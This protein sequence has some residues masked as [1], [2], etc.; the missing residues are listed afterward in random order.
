MRRREFITFLGG[1]AAAWPL[2]A[3]AQERPN[4]TSR[5]AHR[6]PASRTIRNN[7]PRISGVPARTAAIG[8]DRRPQHADRYRWGAAIPTTFANTRR[9]WPRSR[10]TSSWPLAV[11][12]GAVVAGDP[13]RADRVRGRPRSGRRRLRREPGAAGRQRYRFPPVRIQLTGKWLELLKQIAPGVTRAAVLRDPTLTAG[14]G[15]LAV[16]QSVAP[17]LGVEV[18]PDR[19]ARR[20]RDRARHHG[21]CARAERRPDRDGEHLGGAPSRLI[22]ALAARQSCPP[23]TPE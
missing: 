23:S 8:L 12:L 10:R 20:R 18:S 21:L 1:A 7:R 16:I 15:Q 5:R 4:A 6:G 11:R 17:S 14:I 22:V 2:P 13:Y 19:R 3:R 9:N